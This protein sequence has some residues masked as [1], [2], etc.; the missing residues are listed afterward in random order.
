MR[1]Q[2]GMFRRGQPIV[3]FLTT[4][5]AL[6]IASAPM[7]VPAFLHWNHNHRVH[8]LG[9][10]QKY[11]RWDIIN[12]PKEFRLN[13]IHA[14]MLP[15]GKILLVAGSGNNLTNFDDY[16]ND[17]AISVLKTVV[18]NPTTMQVTVVP[19]PSDLFCSGHALLQTGNV[20]IAGG[21]SGYE[22]LLGTVKKAAGTMVIQNEN[23]DSKPRVFK[24]GTAFTSASGKSYVSVQDVTVQPAKKIEDGGNITI[25]HSSTQVF[26]EATSTSTSY[27]TSDNQKYKIAGLTGSDTHNIYGQGGPMTFKKQDYRGDDKSYE[28]DPIAEKYVRTGDLNVSRWYPSLP[29]LTNGHV[30]AV[31]GLDNTGNITSTTEQFDPATQKWTLGQDQAFATYPALFRTQDPNVL[32]YSGSNAGYGPADKGRTPGFWNVVTN[33]FTAVSGLRDPGITETS[34][35]VV[36]PPKVGS[37]DGS[38]SSRIM[39][40][41]G[42][43]IGESKKTT[44]RTDIIDLA[45]NN[46]HYTPGPSLPEPLR[47][48][49]MSITP[50]DEVFANGGTTDYRAKENSYSYTSVMLNPTT[51]KLEPMANELVGRNYHSGSLLLPDGRILVFGG[52]PLYSDK[53]NTTPGQFEQRL[54]VYTAPQLYKSARP[55]L[56]GPSSINAKRS[57]ILSFTSPQASS[58]KTARLIALSTTTHVTNV[59][60]RS[61]AAIEKVVNGKVTVSLPGDENTLPD[62]WY[63]LFVVNGQGTPSVAKMVQIT[64]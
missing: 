55:T 26:V 18:L 12:L 40:A 42:G 16:Y 17:G 57:Q 49:N 3:L 52:D 24:K 35:S 59:E 10:V 41:G 22:V 27:A 36:L 21:T 7:S 34:A 38:Q 63:M 58:V 60:Q 50:W 44:A 46:P 25:T 47:Y 43:G 48:L 23:P 28:F 33:N 19:T 15:T 64:S 1:K 20:L 39:I 30:I 13:T 31:S 51:N 62:G 5:I 11:G 54:E 56:G 32:F 29:V 6:L 61:V 8:A 45:S 53:D 2:P 14:S 37:N 9:Y 4:I